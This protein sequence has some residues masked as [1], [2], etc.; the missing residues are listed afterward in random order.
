MF[1]RVLLRLAAL[2]LLFLFSELIAQPVPRQLTLEASRVLL[3]QNPALQAQR[4][5]IEV[6]KGD[7]IEAEKY[8][9]PE[10]EFT[11]D[12]VVFDS[13]R[14]PFFN[15]LQPSFI[16]RQEIITSGKREKRTRVQA[17]DAE[18]AEIEVD[19]LLRMLPA[20]PSGVFHESLDRPAVVVPQ[21]PSPSLSDFFHF[22]IDHLTSL[23]SCS[24]VISS[25]VSRP[26]LRLILRI[27][28][29]LFALAR[30]RQFHVSR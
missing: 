14:G 11:A 4:I 5:Q 26:S 10:F 25:G 24:G 13:E 9:N 30:C 2:S 28:S 16:L 12:G 1:S 29:N 15:R 19:D 27:C 20:P 23:N 22:A 21:D 18:I 7:V 6:E 8:S 17:A 3:I